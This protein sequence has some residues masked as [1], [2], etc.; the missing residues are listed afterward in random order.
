[1]SSRVRS[2]PVNQAVASG[3]VKSGKA[4]PA[5]HWSH[6]NTDPSGRRTRYPAWRPSSNSSPCWAMYGLIHTHTFRPRSC[7]S[8]ISPSGSEKVS[9]SQ[10]KSTQWKPRIQKQS[11]WN[12]ESGR[13]RSAIPSTKESTVSAS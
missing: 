10:T 3:L 5:C 2:F 13:P 4:M 1:M 7:K 8:R 11:K 9:G 12:T 6:W